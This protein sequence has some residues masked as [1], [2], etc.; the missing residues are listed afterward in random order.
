MMFNSHVKFI[1]PDGQEKLLMLRRGCEMVCIDGDYNYVRINDQKREMYAIKVDS[2]WYLHR[3]GGLPALSFN[4]VSII[5]FFEYGQ[6]KLIVDLNITD[7]EKM[8]L[9]LKYSL[10]NYEGVTLVPRY[11]CYEQ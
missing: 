2:S 10:K 7:V 11:Y 6:S 4:D 9:S 5:S 8:V 3:L 1:S